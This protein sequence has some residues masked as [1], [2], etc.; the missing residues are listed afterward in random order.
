MKRKLT[1]FTLLLCF[2]IGAILPSFASDDTLTWYYKGTEYQTSDYATKQ[3]IVQ[4]EYALNEYNQA[5]RDYKNLMDEFEQTY[6]SDFEVFMINANLVAEAYNILRL[7][8]TKDPKV[9]AE[10]LLGMLLL[11]KQLNEAAAK[12]FEALQIRN[13]IQDQSSILIRE[14]Q[15]LEYYRSKLYEDIYVRHT[16]HTIH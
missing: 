3:H 2:L 10:H 12:E 11:K 15:D 13:R 8:F 1:I 16:L 5:V 14:A 9:V 4:F 6:P 7:G